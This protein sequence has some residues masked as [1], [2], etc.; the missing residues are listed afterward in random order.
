M[1]N[2]SLMTAGYLFPPSANR[3]YAAHVQPGWLPGAEQEAEQGGDS[4]DGGLMAPQGRPLVIHGRQQRLH[5]GKLKTPAPPP[6]QEHTAPVMGRWSMD[7]PGR[8]QRPHLY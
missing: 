4:D 1:S 6:V 5:H 2:H 3:R 8:L 7:I